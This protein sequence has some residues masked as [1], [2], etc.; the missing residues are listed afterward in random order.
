MRR[1]S[2][3]VSS[4]AGRLLLLTAAYVVSGRL[5]LLLAIPPGFA[6]AIFPPVGIGIAAVLLWG[7]PMVAGVLIGSTVLNVSIS[8]SAGNGF[9]WVG[10]LIAFGI[11]IGSSIHSVAGAWFVRRFVGFPTAL[12]TEREVIPFL[13]LA[14]PVACVLSAT[15]G[16]SVLFLAGAVGVSQ[17]WFSW[18][19][20]W[21]GDSTGVLIGLPLML[22]LFAEPRSMWW[23]RRN[24][25]GIPLVVSC[26][27]M[28]T[29]FV[30]TSRTEQESIR[31]E[32]HEHAKLM[33]ASVQLHF[34][35][36][37]KA[38]QSVERFL[39]AAPKSKRNDFRAF[40]S[41]LQSTFPGLRAAS[42]NARVRA[43]ERASFEQ[44]MRAEG[45]TGFAIKERNDA[46]EWVDAKAR[47]EYVVIAY[48][49]PFESNRAAVGYDLASDRIRATACE[50][51]REHRQPAMTA[52]LDL[53]QDAEGYK[54]TLIMFPVYGGAEE[55]RT[56]RSERLR[57]F[58]TTVL[59]IDKLVNAA[60]ATYPPTGFHTTIH[61][62]TDSSHPEIIFGST[63][64]KVP[65]YAEALV[66]RHQ[67][68]M[69][70]RSLEITIAPT[71]VF[72][73]AHRS[74]QSWLVLAGGLT[75]CSLLGAFLLVISGRA[76]HVEQLV[77][78][79]TLELSAI[80]DHAAEAIVTFNSEGRIERANPATAILFD[81]TSTQL[82]GRVMTELLPDLDWKRESASGR[83]RE[84]T[85]NRQGGSPL[86]LEMAVSR[87]ELHGR[88]VFTCMLHDISS[89]KR[90]EQLKNEFVSTVSHELRTPLTSIS[91]SLGLI[92]GGVVGEIS[93]DVREL[94]DIAKTNAERL[95]IL[96]N[97]ILDIDK[98]ESGQLE[99]HRS[100]HDLLQLVKNSMLENGGYAERYGVRLVLDKSRAPEGSVMVDVDASRIM[101]V[102]ANL[103]SN[104][105]KF[106][107]QADQV[108]ISL[109]VID[110]HVKVAVRDHGP[111]VPENFRDR[112]F[113]KFAQADG[114]DKRQR[115]GTGLGLS[116][117]KAIV[118]RLGGSIGF[119]SALGKGS[120]FYFKLP[121]LAS[122]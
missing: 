93:A 65:A 118:E 109:E 1:E 107:P 22:I 115:G 96:V 77:E 108:E 52:P 116:I 113:Q 84:I 60:L 30:R 40:A 62:V 31:A 80:L 24:T 16:V 91:G 103:I 61:D 37:A 112:I 120:T 121:R 21:V 105:I 2:G 3:S 99:L 86:T 54:G 68:Q 17:Y 117:S 4:I 13:L 39:F 47:D 20:W 97:D 15:W 63:N 46:K 8:W 67:W 5:A 41:E 64:H 56:N 111:G 23:G 74:L 35:S 25:V 82:T 95:T 27:L 59:D 18:W 19:T 45:F 55:I 100:P 102:L 6:T 69:A 72:L 81:Y 26:A 34:D 9:S 98:L 32:F 76:S 104:A 110:L 70:G 48:I 106:S 71:D 101:Q 14:S 66:Y 73:Q 85:G 10:L 50:Y 58:A 92:S 29:I 44:S 11:A 42:W 53:V 119:E 83:S 49:E 51:A 43:D 90:S 57:G 33:T 12:S 122:S 28:V 75:L 88:L 38:T 89:R 114:T 36:Y 78:Q 79:R 94:V 7:N 87:M